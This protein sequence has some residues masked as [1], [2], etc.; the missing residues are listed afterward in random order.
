[1]T[2]LLTIYI[3]STLLLQACSQEKIDTAAGNQSQQLTGN[4]PHAVTYEIFVQSFYDTNGDGIGDINGVTE[5]LDYLN[6]LGIE[7]IW[8][9]PINPSPSYHKYDVTD[10]REIHPDYGTLDDFKRLVKEAH[11][12][13]I[14]IMIDLVINHT[15]RDHPWFQEAIV[16]PDSKYRDYYVWAHK[17]SVQQQV[18]ESEL[19][20]DSDNIVK[21]H[22][23]EGDDEL[24]YGYFWGGMPDLNFDN[25]EV[26]EEIFEIGRFW[27][28][29]ME[30]DGFR[31]DAAKHIFEDHRATD[32]HQWWV[33]FRNE[34]N[35]SKPNGEFLLL[36]E[37]WSKAEEVA[38]YLEGLRALFNFDLGEAIINAVSQQRSDSLVERL[39]ITQE[40]YTSINPEYI[41]AIFITNHDQN[42][43]GSRVD[44]HQGKIKMAASL[45]MTLPGSPVIYYGEELGMLGQKPDENIREPFN[46]AADGNDDGE[47]SWVQPLY[48][49]DE[50]VEPLDR[51]IEDRNSV[52]NHYRELIDLRNRSTTLSYGSIEPVSTNSQVCSFLRIYEKDTTWVLHNLSENPQ[53]V[54]SPDTSINLHHISFSNKE[55]KVDSVSWSITLSPFSTLILSNH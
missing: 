34:M 8:L 28:Q 45:L 2:R 33:T 10:Y 17:D 18:S 15:A 41:D 7:A 16:N 35:K 53:I 1:M 49:T 46:W 32:N 9:M 30:I 4:W 37:V 43:I 13:N 31:L 21:W 52:F 22:E 26:K 6:S 47:T 27:F 5:K 14:K 40:Y 48:T 25:P 44:G 3:A 23:V 29:E 50:S 12:R 38:P 51:Q 39:K 54:K 55:F 19:E 36:G 24:Y 20:D 11:D 42:R